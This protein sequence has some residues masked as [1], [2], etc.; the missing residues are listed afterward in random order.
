MSGSLGDLKQL[1]EVCADVG[2]PFED[3]S[4][5]VYARMR[6]LAE[7]TATVADAARIAGLARK[8]FGYY[9][10]HA[11]EARFSEIEKRIVVVGG[12]F[13]DIGKTGPADAD[14]AGQHLV[15]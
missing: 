3:A 8:V 1:Y 7:R 14:V 4:P 12:L 2:V 13:S 9:D 5:V 15:V 6:L 10:R 11:P